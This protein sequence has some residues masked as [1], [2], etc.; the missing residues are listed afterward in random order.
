MSGN[1]TTSVEGSEDDEYARASRRLTNSF[2]AI[3]LFEDSPTRAGR[4]SSGTHEG[5]PLESE[6]VRLPRIRICWLE[7]RQL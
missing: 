6:E 4:T 1:S 2:E 5:L 7:F 3:E